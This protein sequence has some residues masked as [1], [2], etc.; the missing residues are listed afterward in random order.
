M[1]KN[2]LPGT[3]FVLMI[4]LISCQ[5]KNTKDNYSIIPLPNQM[6]IRNG[7]FEFDNQTRF[8]YTSRVDSVSKNVIDDFATQL[9][10]VSGMDMAVESND[11]ETDG[12]NLYFDA[13]T[14]LSKE[15]YSLQ[16][17]PKRI[18]IKAS[19]GSGFFYGINT[20]KQ[21]LPIEIY[22]DTIT[23][24]VKKWEVPCVE[25]ND[26]PRF[27]YRGAHL[28]VSR[29]FFTVDEVKKYIDILAMHKM[30]TFHWHLTD[31]QGWRIE[32][33]KYPELTRIGSVRKKTMIG[34]DWD[35]FDH[36][37]YGGFYTQDEIREIVAYA[38]KHFITVIPE[39][40]MPGHMVA[41]LAT[42]PYLGCT[43]GPYEVRPIWGVADEVLCAGK[44]STYKFVEDVL[45]EVIDLFPSKYIHIGGD[46]CPKTNWE[47]CPYCQARI[48][49]EGL[50]AD[51]DHTAEEK[52]QSYFISRIEKFVN[53]K[54]RQI[55]G[56]DEIL[57]GGLSGNAT[58]MSWRGTEGGIE[59]ARQKHDVIM[60]P[61]NYAYFDYYQ[62]EDTQDEPLAIG[63]YIPLEKV[64]SFNPVPDKLE[65]EFHQYI[66]GAQANMWTEY[67]SDFN[68]IE[69]MLLPRLDAMSEVLWTQPGNMNL[70]DFLLRLKHNIGIYQLKGYNF[71]KEIFKVKIKSSVN[72]DK[73][74]IEAE[75]SCL[76]DGPIYYTLDNTEPTLNS[77]KYDGKPIEINQN[78]ILKATA[79]FSGIQ[80]VVTTKDYLF[81]KATAKKIVLNT[82]PDTRYTFG[83]GN[84]LVDG[85]T[86]DRNFANG[87]WVGFN[88]EN[89]DATI[90]L[91]KPTPISKVYLGML[92][93]KGDWI[94]PATNLKIEVS[95]NN[96]D[97]KTV[98][99]KSFP[100]PKEKETDGRIV[101]GVQFDPVTTQ[102]VRIIATTTDKI[103]SWHPSKGNRAFL[104][105]D[106][107]EIR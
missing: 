85:I 23:S 31:D 37:P 29:H 35:K 54:G 9:K 49:K 96:K 7:A 75:L 46:E 104:F 91:G 86:G 21:L 24:T 77:P 27:A 67:I 80:N 45:S 14:L 76:Y 25:I 73:G 53:S 69:Y 61:V 101:N 40:D 26:A 44:E 102:Y 17:T 64:Y 15:A 87:R 41:A 13:D 79:F 84:T 4:L 68:H 43:G 36:T 3:L 56:W 88:K 78:S 106:E 105:V 57:E 94:F 72:P 52:L 19:S 66:L 63:G 16:V 47:K 92:F 83:G 95:D 48:R 28:D 42:F 58:V 71:S 62:S 33:K 82:Q 1:K 103:P 97:F 39:I 70:N 10:N 60:T 100:T 30:N 81:N 20:L 90:D 22:A 98:C 11:N 59:A 2:L 65:P 6:T 8:I 74:C 99:D 32:I 38:N 107:I 89:L 12:H 34:K 93:L 5:Q 55:I 51:K 50:K 18:T